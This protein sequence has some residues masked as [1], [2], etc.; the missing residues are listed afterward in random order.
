MCF[1]LHTLKYQLGIWAY[2]KYTN[3]EA[4]AAVKR[5]LAHF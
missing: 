1:F 5:W 4:P 2:E 3:K